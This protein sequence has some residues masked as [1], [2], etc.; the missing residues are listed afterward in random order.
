MAHAVL[1][2]ISKA[3]AGVPVLTG[4]SL[5]IGHRERVGLVG[6]NG[7]GKT[8]LLRIIAGLETPD[9]G[10]VD[11]AGGVAI[12]L[13]DQNHPLA[14]DGT[15]E[16]AMLAEFAALSEMEDELRQLEACMADP[17]LPEA[18][19][20]GLE[21]LTRAYG[22]LTER[23]EA[24]GG[25]DYRTRIAQALTGLGFRQ[26]DFAR[27]VDEFSGGERV[28]GALARLLLRGPEL[29]L[30]DEPTNHLDLSATEWLEGFLA[31]Y[32]GAIVIVSH[33]RFFLD[34]LSTRVV[35]VEGGVIRS[36][37]GNYT[38]FVR[39]KEEELLRDAVRGQQLRGKIEQL[40]G[41]VAKFSAG[42]RSVQAK[43]KAKM[44][45][46]V[47]MEAQS[48]R[49]RSIDRPAF[50]F[51]VRQAS[52]RE[53]LHT[54]G[55]AASGGGRQLFSGLDFAVRAGDRLAL[56]GPNGCGKTT[57][58]RALLGEYELDGGLVAWGHGVTAAYLQQD[59]G[60]LDDEV[61]V[62]DELV[63]SSGMLPGEARDL[64]GGFQ[65][66]G[67]DVHKR[68]GD[69]SG[70][71]RCRLAMANILVSG[72]N[73]LLLDEPTNHLDIT[74]RAALEDALGAYRGTVLFVSHDRYFIDRVAGA[75]LVFEA[76][77]VRYHQGNFTSY[78]QQRAASSAGS[79]GRRRAGG[80]TKAP[81]VMDAD[82][83][84]QIASLVAERSEIEREIARDRA[85]GRPR[86]SRDRLTRY[87]EIETL[88]KRLESRGSSRR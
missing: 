88:I 35:E 20:R 23:F 63:A 49:R 32:Q 52:G 2:D 56:V 69:L 74:A 29:L 6:R 77:G 4:V 3:Y 11:K 39:Q 43:S 72:A 60:D 58:L 44:L 27:P 67:D 64:L 78:R 14:F 10:V 83:A 15:L 79:A 28:R 36:Y 24:A 86:R 71:E 9:T 65:F 34:S 25:Y 21:G 81:A 85:A 66:R 7:E 31:T 68:I 75:L 12:G 82:I 80:G 13:L 40:R 1:R 51:E 46:R 57:L 45:A 16:E 33:D 8:T 37:D 42:T 62:L 59:L 19:G 61:T 26:G 22:L 18:R 54:R 87:R 84:A 55:L 38:D 53:V 70:G 5:A 73:V 17:D 50:R 76:D 47:E 41:F 30:L 48:L